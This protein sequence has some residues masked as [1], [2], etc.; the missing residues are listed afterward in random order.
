MHFLSSSEIRL[1]ILKSAL[2]SLSGTMR[3]KSLLRDGP[4]VL[5][6]DLGLRPRDYCPNSPANISAA[7]SIYLQHY[8]YRL[9]NSSMYSNSARYPAIDDGDTEICVVVSTGDFQVTNSCSRKESIY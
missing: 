5:A 6:V 8:P 2:S 4:N 7:M 1:H 9:V 3:L